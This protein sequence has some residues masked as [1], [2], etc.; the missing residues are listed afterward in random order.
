[1]MR[2][3]DAFN[4]ESPDTE[5]PMT[6]FKA[7][8]GTVALVGSLSGLPALA[9]YGGGSGTQMMNPPPGSL[10]N[11][12]CMMCLS[13]SASAQWMGSTGSFH[14]DHIMSR[15]TMMSGAMDLRLVMTSTMPVWGQPFTF[16]PFSDAMT[17]NPLAPGS[18][19]TVD[20]GTMNM[21]GSSMPSGTYY[22]LL[23]MRQQMG[24]M[25][26]A[27]DWIVFPKQVTCDG[28][29]CS[30]A[31]ACMEDANTMCMV[32]GRYR[33]TSYWVDQYAGG[34]MSTLHRT[35]MTDGTG[36]FW[37]NDSNNF[38]YMIRINTATDNGRAWIAIPTFTDVEFNV[39]VEDLVNGQSKSYHS[40][41][42]NRELIYDP[43]F[44]VYP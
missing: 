39:L 2:R 7:L 43:S 37:L 40:A 17:F 36:A 44:F 16:M 27:A 11:P 30:V 26:S 42:G 4:P 28:Q 19:V 6:S 31:S 23:Y 15:Q 18:Q 25:M 1:M 24:P 8:V 35:R 5:V 20:S 9:Q 3:I 32:G 22:M 21:Y 33:I 34:A 13:G 29:G 38:E 14:V 10:Y 41:P 12:Q